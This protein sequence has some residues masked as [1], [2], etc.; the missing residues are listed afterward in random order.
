LSQDG[1]VKL[2]Y[3]LDA[4]E[5]WLHENS[6]IINDK[7]A[8]GLAELDRG[9]GTSGEQSRARLQEKKAAWLK[10]IKES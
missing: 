8:C 7:I 6:D 2:W 4:D 9:E 5:T 1:V 10:T 3:R